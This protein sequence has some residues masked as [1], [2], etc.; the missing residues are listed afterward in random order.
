MPTSLSALSLLGLAAVFG[1]I[2]TRI[3][4][5][6]ATRVG[7]LDS[8]D[9]R[10]KKQAAPVPVAGGIA[11]LVAGLLALA[12]M[13]L[14]DPVIASAILENS[15]QAV[16]LL[17]GAVLITLIG[18]IDDRVNLRARYKLFGQI[19]A[20]LVL[21][22]WGNFVVHSV[23][24]FGSSIEFGQLAI[25]ATVLW[26]LACVNA[27]NLIDGMDGLL[28]TI[29]GIA[30]ITLGVMA[31]LVGHAFAAIVAVALAGAVFGFLR[32]NLPPATI[33]MGD[34]GSMLIGL[35]IGAVAIPASL[36]G[37]ATV[38]LGAPLA[39]LILPAFDTAAAMVRR[40]L[41]GR[42]MATPDRGH[43]HHRMMDSG[44]TPPRV[45]AIIAGLGLIA[46]AGALA[47]T[48]WNNDVFAILAAAGVVIALVAGQLFGNAELSLI[49]ARVSALVR[50]QR[51]NPAD[52]RTWG[53]AIRLQ[54]TA[55][56]DRAW[57]E[58]ATHADRLNLHGLCLDVNAP[59]VHEN[60]RA[61][62]HNPALVAEDRLL[63]VEIPLFGKDN[64]PLGRL[65]VSVARDERPLSEVLAAFA[66]L[67]EVVEVQAADLSLPKRSPSK[68]APATPLPPSLEK[69]PATA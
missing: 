50:G 34:A 43:I 60:Y 5:G 14:I 6:V 10:R 46:A 31:A 56:W 48:A 59:A 45:L 11:V 12:T 58:L 65:S 51:N 30:L 23:G 21:V 52:S 19:A 57:L 53:L 36:K 42:G 68:A 55:D 66:E 26:L 24:V 13:A 18:L 15:R 4:R 69:V 32:W 38:A 22:V 3:A 64:L 41:T 8:P 40:K 33:Y 16:A 28:G 9:G 67:V 20:I 35:V 44:L 47:T 54:G 1:L 25:P 39:V 49:G 2:L 61:W 37:P 63:R 17:V 7:M 62:R 29:G 27:L